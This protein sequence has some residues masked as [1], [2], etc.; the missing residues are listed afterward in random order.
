MNFWEF[1]SLFVEFVAQAFR[2]EDGIFAPEDDIW[3][4]LCGFYLQEFGRVFNFSNNHTFHIFIE[5]LRNFQDPEDNYKNF[6][7]NL[8][9]IIRHDD[10]NE[11][12]RE[13]SIY[14]YFFHELCDIN[15]EDKFPKIIDMC[16]FLHNL[17]YKLK[18]INRGDIYSHKFI[19]EFYY[20]H[21]HSNKEDIKNFF[22]DF[23]K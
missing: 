4:H 8:Y 12:R 11:V 18:A 15:N 17:Y 16:N 6:L 13:I 19:R 9:S 20:R 10:K 5:R 7:L 14:L 1:V 21:R 2:N 3:E 23:L 22:L